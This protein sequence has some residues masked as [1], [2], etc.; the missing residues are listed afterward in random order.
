M[1]KLLLGLAVCFAAALS[2]QNYPGNGWGYENNNS[3]YN[4]GT[5]YFPDDY[6]YEFPSDYYGEDYY[7]DFYRDYRSS[8][9]MIN[10]TGFYRDYRLSKYQIDQIIDLNNQFNSYA[11]WNSYYR[12]NPQRWYYDR[13]YALERILGPKIFIVFQNNYYNGYN[14][15]AY[16][17]SRWENYYR[18][19]YVV[20]PTYVNININ[21]Y[22]VNKQQYHQSVGN[23][24]GW[25]QM[26]SNNS[27]RGEN[28]AN[29]NFRNNV[30]AN[31][32]VRNDGKVTSS[33]V[34]GDNR[35]SAEN[36]GTRNVPVRTP[37]ASDNIPA[38][39]RV[40]NYSPAVP[41]SATV[42]SPRASN[43]RTEP[44]RTA[45][46]APAMGSG[47]SSTNTG[48]RASSAGSSDQR[49]PTAGS[50]GMRN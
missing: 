29:G 48:N 2:A 11:I 23:R 18:P 15:V 1:K 3:G 19:R 26:R 21:Y 16:Y 39:P 35:R 43:T 14:P 41:P 27:F 8:L 32:T 49:N 25:N 31:T 34:A 13:Y 44:S 37:S 5:S 28:N 47:R 22:K 17:H 46:A 50:R 20:R 10:W 9:Q 36:L 7:Q 30:S 42:Q 38:Q 40:R 24:F 6:Y 4:N 33:A 12:A 45:V